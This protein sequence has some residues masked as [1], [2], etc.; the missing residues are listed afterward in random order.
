MCEIVSGVEDERGGSSTFDLYSRDILEIQDNQHDVFVCF[1]FFL[2]IVEFQ[3]L[4][5]NFVLLIVLI[6]YLED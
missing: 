4:R 5:L 6:L 2:I 1:Q 3:D